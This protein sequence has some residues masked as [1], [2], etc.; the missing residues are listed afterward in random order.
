MTRKTVLILSLIIVLAMSLSGCSR[1]KNKLLGSWHGTFD[2]TEV[3]NKEI[4]QD[5]TLGKY[6]TMTDFVFGVTL[7]F[8]EDDTYTLIVDKAQ[9]TDLMDQLLV[10]LE[11]G[12]L[13]YIAD[14]LKEQELDLS[15]DEFLSTMGNS[16]SG[17]LAD[18]LPDDL[19]DVL[20]A[21]IDQSGVYLV[22]DGKLFL[23]VDSSSEID[24]NFYETYTIE[25]DTLTITAGTALAED[26][27]LADVLYPMVFKKT[28]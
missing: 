20:L 11:E 14:M 5:E 27:E 21:E 24:K 8:N 7:T 10:Q 19:L 26:D 6:L 13:L 4:T 2:L 15:V 23:S 16:V 28:Q 18:A 17:L 25:E 3:L 12:L 22:D 9:I 1:E